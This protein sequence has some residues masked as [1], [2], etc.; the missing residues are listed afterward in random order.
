M[1]KLSIPKSRTGLPYRLFLYVQCTPFPAI[2]DWSFGWGLRTSNLGEGAEKVGN[3]TVRKS[4]GEFLYSLHSNGT[5]PLRYLYAFQRYCRFGALAR[6][7][8]STPPLVSTKFSHVPR[9]LG[10]WPLGCKERMCWANCPCN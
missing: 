6:H 10:G 8:F 3:A 2:C 4:V 5:F 7:F 9:G 1:P